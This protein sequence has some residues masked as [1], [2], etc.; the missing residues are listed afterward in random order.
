LPEEF[1]T[2][3]FD[4]VFPDEPFESLCDP[5]TSN[6]QKLQA[7]KFDVKNTILIC[8]KKEQFSSNSEN[9]LT[10]PPFAG[11]PRDRNLFLLNEIIHQITS[12]FN[13]TDVQ[14]E[15]Q[16]TL[17]HNWICTTNNTTTVAT[18][19]VADNE[20]EMWE[21]KNHTQSPFFC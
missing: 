16:K 21:G 4:K 1:T 17:S 12:N 5:W 9:L 14:E 11:N 10:I 6:T 7:F 18:D 3:I 20:D 2:L 15:L 13:A 19:A 8:D